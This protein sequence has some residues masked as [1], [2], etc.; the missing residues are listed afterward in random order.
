[1][2]CKVESK[3][4]EDALPLKVKPATNENVTHQVVFVQFDKLAYEEEIVDQ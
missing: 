2:Y 3:N 1:M 4:S